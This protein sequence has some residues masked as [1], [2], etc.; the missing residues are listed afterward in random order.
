[1]K[2]YYLKLREESNIYTILCGMLNN[3]IVH[4]ILAYCEID[5]HI[6]GLDI[7]DIQIKDIAK[8]IK[9][10]YAV[11]VGTNDYEQSQICAGGIKL[12]EIDENF[13]CVKIR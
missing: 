7:T 9:S 3:R 13:E 12:T 8:A 1:M 5:E 10:F 11:I 6:K 2:K 4:M